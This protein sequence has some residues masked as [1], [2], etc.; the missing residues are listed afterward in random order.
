[1]Q[2]PGVNFVPSIYDPR[3]IGVNLSARF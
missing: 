3:T 1:V 2:G